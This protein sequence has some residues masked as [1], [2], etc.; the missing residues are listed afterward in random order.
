MPAVVV[1]YRASGKT[2]LPREV[3]AELGRAMLGDVVEAALHVGA[4]V[5]VT[6]DPAAVPDGARPLADSGGG[7]GSAV[8]AALASVRGHA[9]VVNAD[10][11][12]VT[13]EALE[14]LAAAGPALVSA[15]DGTTNALSLP[16]PSRFEPLYGAG[17]AARFAATLGLDPVS[18]PELA[19]DVDTL[20]D[21]GALDP[22]SLGP[23]TRLVTDSYKALV[24]GR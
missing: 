12:C 18:I 8:A 16:D 11:P 1:P 2:R 19:L 6:D 5:V 15:R 4:V 23:R 20:D 21:L 9:L 17:S 3:R 24:G 22:G 10:L 13:V 14:L 7:Q